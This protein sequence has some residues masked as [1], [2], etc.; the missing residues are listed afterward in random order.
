VKVLGFFSLAAALL[1]AG[2][3]GDNLAT[4][5][6]P[7]P[8]TAPGRLVSINGTLQPK[9]INSYAFDATTAGEV[10]VT[11]LGAALVGVESTQ[12]LTLGLGIG[13]VSSGGSCL[14]THSV[15]AQG[16]PRAQIT[17]T[18][19]EGRLCVSVFDVGTLTGPANF[20]LTVATP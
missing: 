7:R 5:A 19:Q 11:L 2:C 17:G 1:A 9:G 3:T 14:L 15:N 18:A 13:S 4:T 20:S 12:P 16:G 8:D 10:E 6:L